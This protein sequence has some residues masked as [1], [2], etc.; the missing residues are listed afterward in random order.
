M[1]PRRKTGKLSKH[2]L[3][4]NHFDVGGAVEVH[5]NEY[6]G[7]GFL[8]QRRVKDRLEEVHDLEDFPR[9]FMRV[10]VH[11][12]STPLTPLPEMTPSYAIR[13]FDRKGKE[14]SVVRIF[15]NKQSG[16]KF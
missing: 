4:H 5:R 9:A 8:L 12:S 1:S 15:Q 7:G 13:F 16:Q 10:M 6:P 11:D 2:P 3:F 14:T